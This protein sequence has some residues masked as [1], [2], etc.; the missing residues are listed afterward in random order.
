M[1]VAA[2]GSGARVSRW[3]ATV[4]A[5]VL[6]LATGISGVRADPPGLPDLAGLNPEQ[7]GLAI[8]REKDE[9][10]SGYRDLQVELDMILRD[11]RGTEARRALSI[12]QL[13][14]DDDGDRLL[15]V[16]D[17][18]KPIRGTALLSYTH[19]DGPDDQ[20]LYLPAQR[21][22][23]KIASRNK[24]GPFLSSEFAYEDLALHE[25]EQFSYRL[26]GSEPCGDSQCLR[27]ERIPDDEYSGYSRQEVLLHEPTLRVERIDYF[28]RRERPLKVLVNDDYQLY[29]DRY[30][31]PRRMYME[32]LQTGKTT[33]LLWQQYAFATGLQAERDFS[34]NSLMRAR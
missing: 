30:W 24:S 16:F 11:R 8:F 2:T 17:T 3:G 21:R 23:K 5:W 19:V 14:M 18:P 33:E 22:V 34:T 6:A 10:E 28:D 25:V 27:V 32:N 7:Q 20:W 12:S 29:Q 9:R 13:E 15:V 31:K 1:A 4:L 26:L